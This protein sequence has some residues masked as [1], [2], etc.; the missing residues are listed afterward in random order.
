MKFFFHVRDIHGYEK[1]LEGIELPDLSDAVNEARKAARE[2]VAEIVMQEEKVDSRAF[3]IADGHG[4]ILSTV[5]FKDVI[6]LD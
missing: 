5:P 3:E 4:V 1:D 6:G 2:M